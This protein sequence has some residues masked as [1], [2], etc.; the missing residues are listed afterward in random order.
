MGAADRRSR[1]RL[2]DVRF[3][4]GLL[5]VLLHELEHVAFPQRAERE[6]RSRS[7]DFYRAAL[8]SQ[9]HAEFGADYGLTALS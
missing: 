5:S 9:L 4:V 7:D 8:A 2:E 1:K 6:I 3:H